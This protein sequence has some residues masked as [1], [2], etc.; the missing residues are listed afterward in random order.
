VLSFSP[1]LFLPI[2]GRRIRSSGAAGTGVEGCRRAKFCLVVCISEFGSL[3]YHF[4]H[5][6]RGDIFWGRAAPCFLHQAVYFHLF[7]CV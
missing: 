4:G 5:A 2:V 1:C 3:A 7:I 6:Q